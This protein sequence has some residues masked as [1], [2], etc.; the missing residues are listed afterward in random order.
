MHNDEMTD[1]TTFSQQLTGLQAILHFF[2][3][4]QNTAC[5]MEKLKQNLQTQEYLALL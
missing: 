3:G 4:A 1:S 2:S 5:L